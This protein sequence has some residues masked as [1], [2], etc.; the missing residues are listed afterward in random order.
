MVF[1]VDDMPTSGRATASNSMWRLPWAK[2]SFRSDEPKNLLIM[3]PSFSGSLAS[4]KD[5]LIA[6]AGNFQK[7]TI[8]SGQVEGKRVDRGVRG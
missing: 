2:S 4:L 8:A 5:L 7:I 1:I 3:G 6:R